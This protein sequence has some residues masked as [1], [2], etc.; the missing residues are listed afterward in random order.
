MKIIITIVKLFQKYMIPMKTQNVV[1]SCLVDEIFY[2]INE[3][4]MHHATFI[5]FLARALHD[6]TTTIGDVIDKNVRLRSSTYIYIYIYIYIY[7]GWRNING[8]TI[9]L[10]IF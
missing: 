3:I 4:Y 9:S 2:K 7:T 8:A 1:D 10:Q 6:C 5:A